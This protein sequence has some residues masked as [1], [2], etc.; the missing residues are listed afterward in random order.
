[1][2][3][4]AVPPLASPVLTRQNTILSGWKEI[5]SYMSHGVRTV[6]RWEWYLGLPVHRPHG[7][8]RSRVIA[9]PKELDGWLA[10]T[11]CRRVEPTAMATQIFELTA[12][13]AQLEAEIETLRAQLA[14]TEERAG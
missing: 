14:I 8:P 6:Q 1:M 11:P 10:A 9:F 13:I 5:A 2:H 4:Q 7:E 12:K 3:I